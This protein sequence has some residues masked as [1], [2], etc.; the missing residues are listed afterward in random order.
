MDVDVNADILEILPQTAMFNL[1]ARTAARQKIQRSS[2]LCGGAGEDFSGNM[3]IGAPVID[4]A[5]GT[6]YCIARS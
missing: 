2:S 6:M 1:I 4:T 3:D 5:A